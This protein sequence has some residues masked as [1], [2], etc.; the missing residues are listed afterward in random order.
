M[1]GLT[2]VRDDQVKLK[3]PIAELPGVVEVHTALSQLA[4]GVAGGSAAYRATVALLGGHCSVMFLGKSSDAA[5][6][7]AAITQDAN[8]KIIIGSMPATVYLLSIFAVLFG[9]QGSPLRVALDFPAQQTTSDYAIAHMPRILCGRV[10]LGPVAMYSDTDQISRGALERG[11]LMDTP[12]SQ[13]LSLGSSV[14]SFYAE[15]AGL[16]ANAAAQYFVKVNF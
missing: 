3:A 16:I 9:A 4:S 11:H 8:G 2:E 1:T 14:W 13:H 15:G 7:S 10:P 6:V 5:A 12:N